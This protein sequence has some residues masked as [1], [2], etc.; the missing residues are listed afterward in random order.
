MNE[1][2]SSVRIF[3]CDLCGADDP[4][5]VECVRSYTDNQP[6]HL[7]RRCGL[8]YVRSRRDARS[9]A[10]DWSNSLYVAGT[11]SGP[12]YTARR[13][14]VRAR[15]MFVAAFI[16]DTIGTQGKS[17]CDIGAGEGEFLKTIRE[18]E[19][20]ASVFGIEP[21][22]ANCRILA[23]L[24]IANF[25]GTIEDYAAGAAAESQRFD[26]ITIMWTLEACQ[27]PSQMLDAA[28]AILRDD[29]HVVVATGS[30]ILVPFKKPLQYY[31]GA[32]PGDLYPVRYSE[33]TLRG[34]LAV[35]GFETTH[36]NRFIDSD[37][38]C[39]V[40]RKTDRR[41]SLPWE[42]DDYRKVLAFFERWHD[43]TRR[44]YAD[45]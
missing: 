22:V 19:F 38:L 27:N 2:S 35:R 21:S 43:E 44:F 34:H 29:G 39:V 7:C 28:H 24:G 42:K 3:S 9:I 40:A 36:V 25:E 14:A 17:L 41:S 32:Q 20:R 13:P 1:S 31:L 18:D 4:V 15:Q 37:V 33:R 11:P 8:V 30:R 23:D 12:H 5:E 6:I 26:I 16:A 10:D 45:A